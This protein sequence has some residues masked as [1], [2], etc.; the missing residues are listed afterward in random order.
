MKVMAFTGMPGSGKSVVVDALK[1]EGYE[2]LYMGIIVRNEMTRSNIEPS[3]TNVRNFATELRE[4]HGEDI[5][6]RK[7]MPELLEKIKRSTNK[8][9]IIEDIKGI[10]EVEYF[11]KELGEDF[12]LIAIH[13]PP[14][15]RF[16]RSRNRDSEWDD[17]TIRDF[18]EFQWR[19]KK[20]MAWGLSDAIALADHIVVNDSSEGSLIEKVKE[21]IAQYN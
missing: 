19:D 14:R 17:K 6:A 8:P 10:A 2:T 12:A 20:E 1:K 4:K 13:T 3:G 21:L 7:C 9:V 16:Q 15:L 5:V 18:E 11:R